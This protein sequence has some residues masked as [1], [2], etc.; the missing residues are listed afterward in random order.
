MNGN[1][2]LDPEIADL[3]G[4][5]SGTE[6]PET[7]PAG[8]TAPSTKQ[9]QKTEMRSLNLH[10]SL[11]NKNHYSKIINETGEYGTRFNEI[12]SKFLKATDKDEK[13]MCRER[14]TP[15]YWNMLTH[16]INNFFDNLTDEKQALY[17]YGLLNN[18]FI[19]ESQK[20]ILMKINTNSAQEDFSFVDEWLLKVGNGEISPSSV[21]E[22][23]K[24]KKVSPSAVKTKLDRKKGS[25]SAELANFKQK[26]GQ[27]RIIEKSLKSCITIILNHDL[28]SEY[29]NVIAPYNSEQK[30]ALLQVQNIVKS[31]IKSDKDIE[32]SY[33][34]L[35]TLDM[36]IKSLQSSGI[37]QSVEVDTKTVTEEFLSIR[38]MIKLAVGRQGNHFPFL[39]KYYLPNSDIEV[40]TKNNL[41]KILKEIEAIDPGVFIRKYKQEEHRIVPH[42]IIVPAYGNFGICWEPFERMN[43]ATSKGRIAVPMFP[44]DLKTSV[45]NALGDLRWQIAKEKA[46]HY[47][48][49]EGLTGHYYEYSQ[50]NKLKGDLKQAFIQD[51]ILWIKF[52]SQGMQ[53]LNREVRTIFWRYIPFP[54][55]LKDSLKNRGFYYSELYKKDQTR[56]MS[57]G[58]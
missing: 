54:Q 50:N 46:L 38:Q 14:L 32:S 2:E 26:S 45:L 12:L 9:I 16:L 55:E 25:K 28:I 15:A 33:R 35:M 37:D 4:I 39:I 41:E 51:Y 5:Q 22:T 42:F 30:K 10:G 48:M 58:Y 52:E 49:E 47:W 53:K 11:T 24:A 17:R 27:H 6:E 34:A 44:R 13:S 36:E 56:A 1:E 40:C 57:R 29:E 43:K 19:D 21:D 3:L 20:N 18:T 31:L 23:A 7:G 8:Q